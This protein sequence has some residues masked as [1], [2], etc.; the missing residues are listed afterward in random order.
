M[1]GLDRTLMRTCITAI[2]A[3]LLAPS[4]VFADAEHVVLRSVMKD[5]LVVVRKDGSAYLAEKGMGCLSV[6]QYQGRQVVIDSPGRFLGVG[7]RLLLPNAEQDCQIWQ[8]RAVDPSAVNASSFFDSHARAAARLDVLDDATFFL[9]SGE[10][11]AYVVEDSIVGFNGKHLGWLRNG[12]VYD[13]AG[14]IVA[15]PATAFREPVLEPAVRTSAAQK[16]AKKPAE[17]PPARP[18]FGGSWSTVPARTFFLS[19]RN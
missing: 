15:A 9:W 3:L 5:K 10:P 6:S 4:A 19:G 8:A 17:Q 12:L 13:R 2:L 11:V 1:A 14:D 18:A 7:S 16:P